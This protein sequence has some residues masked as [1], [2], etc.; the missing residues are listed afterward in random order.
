[1]S[2]PSSLQALALFFDDIRL[3]LGY[4]F[5]LI[6]QYL[7]DVYLPPGAPP[8]DRL[9]ILLIAR[10]PLDWFPASVS[11]RVVLPRQ[12]P[13]I[14][15]LPVQPSAMPPPAQTAFSGYNFQAAMNLRFAP[16]QTGDIIEVWMNFDGDYVPAGRLR[17][18]DS[19]DLPELPIANAGTP[20]SPSAQSRKRKKPARL[21]SP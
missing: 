20:S 8:L 3:E 1:M 6:G 2:A 14:Q 5:T 4:K 19:S 15:Q 21:G 13:V 11:A 7:G 17:F 16:L 18:I 10:W 9:A 12:D